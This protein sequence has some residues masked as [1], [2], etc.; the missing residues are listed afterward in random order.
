MKS[1]KFN[2]KLK[3]ISLYE[4]EKELI[5]FAADNI[6]FNKFSLYAKYDLNPMFK[7]NPAKQNNISLGVRFDMN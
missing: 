6:G 3:V 7:N 5:E 1:K 2:I 4:Q